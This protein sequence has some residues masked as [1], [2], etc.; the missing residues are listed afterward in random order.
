VTA[1]VVEDR[2]SGTLTVNHFSVKTNHSTSHRYGLNLGHD[3]AIR[4]PV[5]TGTRAPNQHFGLACADQGHARTSRHFQSLRFVPAPSAKRF[6]LHKPKS[7]HLSPRVS[8]CLHPYN[9]VQNFFRSPL[10]FPLYLALRLCR[11]PNGPVQTVAPPSHP[12]ARL[13]QEKL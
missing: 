7:C 13:V 6:S 12:G 1:R 4:I 2:S 8:T 5:G 9:W 11:S 3:S 10:F